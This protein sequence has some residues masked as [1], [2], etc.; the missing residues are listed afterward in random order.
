MRMKKGT[1]Y[2]ELF[3][4]GK[5]LELLKG[6][7]LTEKP[8]KA[9]I[10]K[11]LTEDLKFPVG[12]TTVQNQWKAIFPDVPWPR[13]R[14][15]RGSRT[16]TNTSRL[17]GGYA[18]A[19]LN[20]AL[21]QNEAIIATIETM[22]DLFKETEIL[23]DFQATIQEAKDRYNEKL[24]RNKPTVVALHETTDPTLFDNLK[25]ANGSIG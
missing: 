19:K 21:E 11:M 4:I 1:T 14:A 18:Y 6:H 7:I 3:Q 15:E 24:A 16:G 2:R 25:D 8:S 20:L 5:K 23:K 22:L 13:M 12:K 9:T 17:K 10:A